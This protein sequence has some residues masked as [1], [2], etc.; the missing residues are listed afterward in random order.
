MASYCFFTDPVR[1]L[2]TY[3]PS[4][5]GMGI[6][7]V[8]EKSRRR[9]IGTSSGLV[10]PPRFNSSTPVAIILI[11]GEIK[12]RS[13]NESQLSKQ[14]MSKKTFL[15]LSFWKEFEESRP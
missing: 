14:K 8:S 7:V 2:A 9:N 12:A 5:K 11:I 15:F 10:G 6:K 13:A 1:S 3:F 4:P